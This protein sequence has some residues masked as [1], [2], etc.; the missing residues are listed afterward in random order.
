MDK[1]LYLI[2]IDDDATEAERIARTAKINGITVRWQHVTDTAALSKALEHHPQAV[3]LC[4]VGATSPGFEQVL[5]ITRE[6]NSRAPVIAL[7]GQPEGNAVTVMQKGA[8]DLVLKDE[9]E[10][11]KL[12]LIRTAESQQRWHASRQLEDALRESERQCRALLESSRDAICYVHEG[13]HVYANPAYLELFG[14]AALADVEGTPIMDMVEHDHQQTLKE[15]L[16]G[17]E[18]ENHAESR[19]DIELKRLDGETFNAR[20]LFCTARIDGEDCIQVVIPRDP[21]A[22]FA[23]EPVTSRQDSAPVAEPYIPADVNPHPENTAVNTKQPD[24]SRAEAITAHM[25]QND[26][27]AIRGWRD[28]LHQQRVRLVFQPIVSLRGNP[29]ERFE[30]FVRAHDEADGELTFVA[31]SKAGTELLDIAGELDRWLLTQAT[32]RLAQARLAD[33]NIQFLIR[34]GA[35]ALSDEGLPAWLGE[36]LR[37]QRVPPGQLVIGINEQAVVTHFKPARMLA[38]KLHDMQILL[39]LD[40]FSAAPNA[41]ELLETI[42]A[43]FL[44]LHG[45]LFGR[46]AGD[47]QR[48]VKLRAA[49]DRIHTLNKASIVT[50]VDDA[51]TLSVLWSVGVNY[52]Q[53]NFLRA[54]GESLDYDF[55]A[56]K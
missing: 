20:M 33:R 23:L 51:A 30:V 27:D 19:L 40:D 54:P 34:L 9:P 39:A 2:L 44:R 5:A 48:L 7:A 41:F 13:M 50:H 37:S 22:E 25:A 1:S 15:L 52:V 32:E 4:D 18:R 29:G 35:A 8:V 10:H 24:Q 36:Q 46:L 21:Y 49:V 3:V 45:G 43:D 14:Y 42:P 56:L 17:Q 55:S 16:R 47:A 38:Q 26:E 31:P 12:V 28:A 6:Q 11:L 53:G